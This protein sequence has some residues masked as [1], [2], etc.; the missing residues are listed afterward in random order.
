M[1]F[2]HLL[3]FT[4]LIVGIGLSVLLLFFII[5]GESINESFLVFIGICSPVCISFG[6]LILY[7]SE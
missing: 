4:L 6:I 1:G 2:K 7:R 3:G 5:N